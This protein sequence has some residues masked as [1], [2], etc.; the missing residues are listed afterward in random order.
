MEPTKVQAILNWAQPLLLQSIQRFLGFA[1]YYRQ[2][3]K[4]LST[5]VALITALTRKGADPS[6]WSTEAVKAFDLLM[7]AFISAQV[8]LHPDSSLTFLV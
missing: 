4:D 8:H 5:L 2:F 1:N 6:I 7:E 3:I